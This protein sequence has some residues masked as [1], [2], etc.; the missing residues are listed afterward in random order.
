MSNEKFYRYIVGG[1]GLYAAVD[2]DCPKDDPRRQNKPD[3][4]WLPKKGT[5]YPGAISFWKQFGLEKYKLSGL[6]D[7]HSSVVNGPVEERIIARPSS[8]MYE[9][10]YQIIVDPA[11]VSS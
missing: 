2:H 1:I 6:F 9:D 10:E 11:L 8:V 7:W 3:G 4:S 5:D